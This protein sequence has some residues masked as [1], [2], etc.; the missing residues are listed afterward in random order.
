MPQHPG[1][2]GCRLQGPCPLPHAA[3]PICSHWWGPGHEAVRAPS[4]SILESHSQWQHHPVSGRP[5]PILSVCVS[6]SS[7]CLLSR[8]VSQL[9]NPQPLPVCQPSRSS[10]RI[11]PAQRILP[12]AASGSHL[13]TGRSSLPPRAM[14]CLSGT[15]SHDL[16]CLHVCRP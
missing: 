11:V 8:G 1:W 10:A 15:V 7:S 9:P 13:A 3:Q 16:V 6:T 4:A 12:V 5:A 2:P 14:H